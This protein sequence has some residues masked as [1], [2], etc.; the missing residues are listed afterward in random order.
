LFLEEIA[1]TLVLIKPTVTSHVNRILTK[2]DLRDRAPDDRP[3]LRVGASWI[4][5]G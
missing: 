4:P 5:A 2:L 3:R 1:S